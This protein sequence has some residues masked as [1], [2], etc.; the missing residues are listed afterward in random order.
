MFYSRFLP[1]HSQVLQPLNRLLRKDVKWQWTVVEDAAF[2]EAKMLLL[3]SQTLVHFDERLP[4]YLSCDSSSYGAGAVLSHMIDGT[5]RPIAF[6]SISLTSAQR[7]YSQIEKE[8]LSIIFGLKK[9]HQF[10]YG[11]S[12]TIITDHKP[13]LQLFSPTKPVPHHCA[14]RLQR[15]ALLLASYD[16]KL[17]FRP[18]AAHSDADSVSRLPLPDTFAPKSENSNCFF[19]DDDVSTFVSHKSIRRQTEQDITLS[20]VVRFVRD[21]WPTSV[22]PDLVPYKSKQEGLTV[23]QGCLLW[24]TRIIIPPKLQKQVLTELHSTHPGIVKMKL[25]ARSYVWWPNLDGQIEQ[26]VAQ[27]SLCQEMRSDPPT[28]QVHPWCFPSR[29]WSRIHLDYAGPIDGHMY[30]VLVDAFSKY[31]EITKMSSTTSAATVN[32]LRDIFSRQGLPELIVSDNGPQFVSKEFES[33]CQQNGIMHRTSA[34]YKPS[35]N[36]QA[37]RVVQILKSAAKQAHFR[38]TTMDS[39]LPKY[40]LIYRTT[41]HL[42]TGETPAK[43]LMGRNLRTRLD[44]LKPSLHSHVE[45][46][47]EKVAKRS[48]S[49]GCRSFMCGDKVQARNYGFGDKWKQGI[50]VEILGN[51]HY[52]VQVKDKLWKR[53][54]D[55]LIGCKLPGCKTYSEIP[56]EYLPMS[57]S[58]FPGVSSGSSTA[59]SG[60]TPITVAHPVQKD[61]GNSSS[62]VQDEMLVTPDATFP[63]AIAP[64]AM[65]GPVPDPVKSLPDRDRRPPAYLKDY[66]HK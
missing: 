45:K 35:S 1:S 51:K 39:I 57:S 25:L 19:I 4:L 65:K 46:V 18:T 6:A 40:L 5:Y 47:Q 16:Y 62:D 14:A 10:L 55:Q 17:Q 64:D 42:T 9:F 20:K 34:V 56:E 59:P 26:M 50:I 8:A 66:V 43:L 44:L 61:H 7:N 22:E 21:G 63:E 54:I 28:A 30:L 41:P 37:E 12:F 29:P 33:F 11:R 60:D 38:H 2:K 58:A 3:N 23:E 36:G 52:L 53:H 32:A 15:W 48:E 27:C 13:L 24:G 49:R 31:P